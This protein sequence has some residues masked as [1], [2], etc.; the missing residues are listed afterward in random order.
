MSKLEK[1]L[2]YALIFFLPWQTRLIL[3]SWNEPFSEWNSVALYLTDIIILAIVFLWVWRIFL[4][5]GNN[6]PHPP[7]I[8][9]GGAIALFAFLAIG[10]LSLLKAQ[11]FWLGF[12]HEIKLVEMAA[13]F[14]YVKNN[15]LNPP[16]PSFK[17]EGDELN[18]SLFKGRL[19]G[20][21]NLFVLSGLL[22]SLIAI[23]QFIRQKSFGLSFLDESPLGAGLAG[24]AKIV[25]DGEKIIRPYGLTPHP[26]ILAA[27]L[28]I[29]IFCALYLFTEKNKNIQWRAAVGYTAI[30]SVL[31]FAFFLTFSRT[32]IIIG[33]AAIFSWLFYSLFKSKNIWPVSIEKS[34]HS[35]LDPGSRFINLDSRF[36]SFAK[37]FGRAQ[38]GNDT[39]SVFHRS[40][41]VLN[42]IA[43][44]AASCLLVII[45][46]WPF[47]SARFDA[48]TAL[49]DQSLNLRVFYNKT[50]LQFISQNPLFGV[51]IGNFVTAFQTSQPLA[52][53]WMY[54][55]AHNIYLLVASEIGILGLLAFLI[56]LFFVM[57]KIYT[58]SL[59][60][61][62]NNVNPSTSS[63][64]ER[65]SAQGIVTSGLW[66]FVIGFMLIVGMADHFFWT[67]QQGQLMF[68]I[69]LGI[70]AGLAASPRSSTG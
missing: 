19:G 12:F 6:S 21:F 68:W 29:A 66:L 45:L 7:L 43:V 35:G 13:L 39:K 1:Y 63:R 57:L 20:I 3:K 54:Q 25:V 8:L 15:I 59:S 67:L 62:N 22:Q 18:L 58:L 4:K 23:G 52:E 49:T 2:F 33:L 38:R 56:L 26:N 24:V 17:K 42:T 30:L 69:L 16:H 55:P 44:F 11:N 51:G 28:L 37:G 34:C 41:F 60:N 53:T 40:W 50:A 36:P 27:F 47:L 61:G 65:D 5:N 46:L 70:I 9:R 31:V 48:G 10:A 64:I 32:V 14:L